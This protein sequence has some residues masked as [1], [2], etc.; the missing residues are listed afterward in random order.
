MKSEKVFKYFGTKYQVAKALKIAPGTV[1]AWGE[2]PPW[3]RQLELWAMS[4][5]FLVPEQ[6]V[7]DWLKKCDLKRIQKRSKNVEKNW[8]ALCRQR[9]AA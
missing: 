2:C 6:K 4:D 5:G 9:N 1:L 3:P 8:G 7:L